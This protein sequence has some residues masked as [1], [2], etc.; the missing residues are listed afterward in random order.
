MENGNRQNRYV[1][2]GSP[3]YAR[4]P[5][6]TPRGSKNTRRHALEAARMRYGVKRGRGGYL[7]YFILYDLVVVL[8]LAIYFSVHLIGLEEELRANEWLY[9]TNAYYFKLMWGMA[10]F[11]YLI[12]LMPLV[13]T[14]LHQAKATA[15]DQAGHLV[16][17]LKDS[18][19]K[20]KK[21]EEEALAAAEAMRPADG[22]GTRCPPDARQL[23]HTPVPRL[24]FA[25]RRRNPCL[26]PTR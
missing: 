18:L 21:A 14:A 16:P 10:S 17:K 6:L 12:F 8:G 7:P 23:P 25:P 11:P 9:W 1:P 13:G 5:A 20:Q 15:Y 2:L 24:W 22:D 19:V 3:T 26:P 4:P